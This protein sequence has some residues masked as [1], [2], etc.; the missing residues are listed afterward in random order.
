VIAFNV[1]APAGSAGLDW[2]GLVGAMLPAP[3]ADW[4]ADLNYCVQ[5][6]DL[7]NASAIS[8]AHSH[9]GAVSRR[10]SSSIGSWP[11]R[12]DCGVRHDPCHR[13]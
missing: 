12:T 10:K 7:V 2:H 8:Y 5:H 3:D 11:S 1:R 13:H 9:A 6:V 4:R